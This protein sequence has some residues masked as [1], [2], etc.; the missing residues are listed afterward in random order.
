M[1]NVRVQN[2]YKGIMFITIAAFCF[3]LMST[4]VKCAGEL[5]AI[6]KSFFRNIVAAVISFIVLKK[7]KVS[8]KPEKGHTKYL[9]MRSVC[10]TSGII[11]NYCAID[12]LMVPDASMLNKLSPFFVIIFS[13]LFLKEKV[14]PYQVLCLVIAFIGA[15]FV[16]KP[17]AGVFNVWAIVG[18]I[19]GLSAG[20]A[21]TFVRILGKR[22]ANGS[23][24]V[25]FFSTFSSLAA[26]P[27]LIFNPQTIPLKQM[28]LLLGAGVAS[29]GGQFAI[30]A[31]Y[32]HSPAREI[33]IFDY[34]QIIFA[35]LFS[36]FI[37][38]QVPDRYSFIGYAIICLASLIMFVINK[39]KTDI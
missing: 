33:S 8:L 4:L 12:H 26:L 31:A 30:T 6:H 17:G 23:Y 35:T 34:S 24:I 7:E 37:L 10:G 20:A 39:K 15:L 3:A 16:I 9:I 13:Y 19:G 2:R 14:K 22:K 32:S 38:G 5:P 1:G 36:F 18:T 27:F 29:C 21:Y 25:W 28:L 11:C